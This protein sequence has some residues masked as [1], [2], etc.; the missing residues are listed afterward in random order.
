LSVF[1]VKVK[2]EVSDP[3]T[4]SLTNEYKQDQLISATALPENNTGTLAL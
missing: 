1:I 2:N 4:I 3:I